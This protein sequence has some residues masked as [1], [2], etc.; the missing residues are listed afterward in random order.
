M[1]PTIQGSQQA[2]K[3]VARHHAC[4]AWIEAQ[5]TRTL[6]SPSLRV[7]PVR[8]ASVASVIAELGKGDRKLKPMHPTLTKPLKDGQMFASVL[9][10]LCQSLRWAAPEYELTKG[11]D[12]LL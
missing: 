11:D 12:G 6:V 8:S 3:Q 5:I 10:E 7:Q 4:L 1:V 2:R 9:I